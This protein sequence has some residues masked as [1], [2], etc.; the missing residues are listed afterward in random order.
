M[1]EDAATQERAELL[2]DGAGCGMSALPRLR[3][4]GFELLANRLVEDGL[5]GVV[6]VL[7]RAGLEVVV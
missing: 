2:L 7:A 3:E 6:R 1:G 4:E 5:L